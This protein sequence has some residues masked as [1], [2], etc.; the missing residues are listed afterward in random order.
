MRRWHEELPRMMRWWKVELRNH[1]LDPAPY[2][3][4]YRRGEVI[5]VTVCR[6]EQGPGVVRK[7]DPWDCGRSRCGLC[8][9]SR[10]Y[11]IRRRHSRD[12]YALQVEMAGVID[13][14]LVTHA[15][16]YEHELWGAGVVGTA[17]C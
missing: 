8:H 7:T 10:R 4:A 1:G 9:W 6:C 2:I 11:R 5:P 16:R 15:A 13:G 17:C 12:R 3:G 14:V